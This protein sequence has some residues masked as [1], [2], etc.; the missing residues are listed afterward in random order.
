MEEN[1]KRAFTIIELIAVIGLILLMGAAGF[2]QMWTA[3]IRSDEMVQQF[4]SDIRYI[5]KKTLYNDG[6]TE[7]EYL[8]EKH[9]S[10]GKDRICGYQLKENSIV[11]KEV[12]FP[13]QWLVFSD[14]AMERIQFARSG[15]F[16]E[17]GETIR[18]TDETNQNFYRITIV[19]FSGRVEV[20]K[21]E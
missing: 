13:K 19:P 18:I 1:R 17:S 5:S 8:F 2:H 21:N 6:R 14:N 16:D 11:I 12:S 4:A 15:E 3:E 9:L 20:Y 10:D 7:L